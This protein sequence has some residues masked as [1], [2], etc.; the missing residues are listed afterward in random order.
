MRRA[1]PWP[2]RSLA[3]RVPCVRRLRSAVGA[4]PV[5][6]LPG[7]LSGGWSRPPGSGT[8]LSPLPQFKK[9]K[10]AR[11]MSLTK[12]EK[13]PLCCEVRVREAYGSE[14]G[15]GRYSQFQRRRKKNA[16]PLIS[17]ASAHHFSID[18]F[19]QLPD[20]TR[21]FIY[22]FQNPIEKIYRS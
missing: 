14:E 2:T 13:F 20:Y 17:G 3:A 19:S 5:A 12:K 7:Q 1:F 22:R 15:E 6:V 16:E 18:T 9:K 8:G 11:V 4:L 10:R 21:K